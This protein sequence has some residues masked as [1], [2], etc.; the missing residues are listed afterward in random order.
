MRRLTFGTDQEA[1]ATVRRIRGI[2]DRVNGALQHA[3]EAY[4]HGTQYS[5]HDPALPLWV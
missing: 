5:A 2:H 3:A 4:P 1:A